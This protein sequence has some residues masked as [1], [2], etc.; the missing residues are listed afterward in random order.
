MSLHHTLSLSDELCSCSGS[1]LA[2]LTAP[3]LLR[4]THERIPL[5]C[6]RRSGWKPSMS[7]LS[8]DH[9]SQRVHRTGVLTCVGE[10]LGYDFGWYLLLWDLRWTS[11]R[12]RSL[13][14]TIVG[15]HIDGDRWDIRPCL[16]RQLR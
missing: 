8:G 7:T 16:L 15:L 9:L 12:T 2:L 14:D 6:C 13:N 1:T 4:E 5:L 10:E 3:G 11:V